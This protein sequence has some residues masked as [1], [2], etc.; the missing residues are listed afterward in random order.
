MKIVKQVLLHEM[1]LGCYIYMLNMHK[2]QMKLMF[3]YKHKPYIFQQFKG[4]YFV[5]SYS[6]VFLKSKNKTKILLYL[7][8]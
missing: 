8:V 7:I 4:N 6:L 2:P 5:Y 1:I 3:L